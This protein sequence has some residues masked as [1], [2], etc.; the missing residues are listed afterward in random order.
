MTPY[1]AG[2]DERRMFFLAK[3]W[4]NSLSESARVYWLKK[5]NPRGDASVEEAW[6]CYRESKDR[7]GK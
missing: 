6:R 5:V 2:Y 1:D 3:S 7:V 4:W